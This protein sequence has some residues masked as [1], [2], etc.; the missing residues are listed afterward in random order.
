MRLI[1]LNVG[2]TVTGYGISFTLCQSDGGQSLEEKGERMELE[3]SIQ[4]KLT[5]NVEGA[6]FGAWWRCFGGAAAAT[7]GKLHHKRGARSCTS[8]E[9]LN[10]ALLPPLQE[11]LL[12]SGNEIV[13]S[14]VC[15]FVFG[16]TLV[17]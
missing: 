4:F 12:F 5:G 14:L 1:Q 15:L 6:S 11:L 2:P 8:A 10:P 9:T 3:N 13:C 7:G 16:N 17:C